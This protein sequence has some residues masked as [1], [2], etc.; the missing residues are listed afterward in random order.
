MFDAKKLLDALGTPASASAAAPAPEPVAEKKAESKPAHPLGAGTL[1]SDLIG[2]A[3][4]PSPVPAADK[5]DTAAPPPK[6]AAKPPSDLTDLVLGRAQDYLRSPQ[7][8][9]AMNAIVLGV[10]KA[11]ANSETGRKLAESAKTK[12]TAL[13]NRFLNK[14][15]SRPLIDAQPVPVLAAPPAV[16]ALAPPAEDTSG[17]AQTALLVVRAMIAAAA[18]DGVIDAGE[19]ERILGSLQKAGIAGTGVQLVE[20]ELARP[21][22][23][24]E[25]AAAATTPDMALQAYMAAR[26]V[27]TP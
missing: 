5:T 9:A 12:G 26:R 13:F 6:P 2:I 24:A 17:A 25:L 10:T 16:P 15:S 23:V 22:S 3:N 4:Q 14:G 18:S 21:A 27:I 19:R 11:V 7:G 8:N 1:L 20:A